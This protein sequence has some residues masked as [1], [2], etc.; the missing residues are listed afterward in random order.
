MKKIWCQGNWEC[1]EECISIMFRDWW[2][3]TYFNDKNI[4]AV[5]IFMLFTTRV[6]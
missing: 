1:H 3:K 5:K 6:F 2:I 4:T